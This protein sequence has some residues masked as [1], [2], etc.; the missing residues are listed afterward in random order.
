MRAKE[1]IQEMNAI[2][3]YGDWKK[4]KDSLGLLS[5]VVLSQ[6]YTKIADILVQGGKK[7]A[8][9]I[10]ENQ[11]YYIAGYFVEKDNSKRFDILLKITLS[12]QSSLSA[13]L[14]INNLFNV[15]EVEVKKNNRGLGIALSVYKYFITVLD[16]ALLG[17]KYQ[18]FGARRLWSRLST[19]ANI[20]VS[21]VNYPD[22]K[23]LEPNNIIAHGEEDWQFDDRVWSY[24]TDKKDIRLLATKR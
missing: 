20:N 5:T 11:Q 7:L 23:I 24:D 15:D 13:K 17:D 10:I 9:Y 14:N 16:F 1:V 18:F 21:I 3:V 12:P 19:E 6:Y 22:G 8:L 2:V 4:D